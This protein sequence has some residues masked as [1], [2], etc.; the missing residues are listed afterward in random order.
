VPPLLDS[1]SGL[2]ERTYR[3]RS[4]LGA[5]GPFVI[6]DRGYRKL[7]GRTR[8][9]RTVRSAAVEAQTLVRETDEGVLACI[10]FPDVLIDRLE[11]YP[12]QHGIGEQNVGAFAAFVEEID[13]LLVIAERCRLDRPVSLFELELHANVSK[14]LVL[15]RFLAGRRQRLGG[16]R[17]AW[18]RQQLFGSGRYQDEDPGVQARYE[19]AARWAVKLL[20]GLGRLEA[21]ERLEALRRFHAA[22][23]ADKLRMIDRLA[24]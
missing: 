6:G 3:L 21:A 20:D 15:A 5:L 10:Y 22:D 13:H 8:P 24:A 23:S 17:G 19:D 2:I 16:E 11:A 1:V 9:E 12:P 7:Y 4:G 18:L 14:H